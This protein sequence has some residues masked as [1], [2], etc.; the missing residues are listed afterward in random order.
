MKGV[1]W[2]IPSLRSSVCLSPDPGAQD[3][4]YG[5][6]IAASRLPSSMAPWWIGAIYAAPFIVGEG[7]LMLYESRSRPKWNRNADVL[8]LTTALHAQR[9]RL[10]F[11]AAVAQ[12]VSGV[13]LIGVSS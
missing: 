1:E 5:L 3:Y 11:V 12:S 6:S 7:V 4:T 8:P 10:Q 2:P 9:R 13:I